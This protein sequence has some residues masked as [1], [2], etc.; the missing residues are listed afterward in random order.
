MDT[1]QVLVVV[2]VIV[3][4][5]LSAIA[6]L[7]GGKTVTVENVAEQFGPMTVALKE[8][9]G[10]VY[11][12]E[13]LWLTGELKKSE[14]TEYV[15]AQLKRVLPDIDDEILLGAIRAAVAMAKSAI[16]RS[17][18]VTDADVAAGITHAQ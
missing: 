12:A 11:D 18:G 15:L 10:W 17:S 16:A 8:A 14:R 13:Q 2:G 5:I 6:A 1:G 7:R 3:A 9:Q 4:V